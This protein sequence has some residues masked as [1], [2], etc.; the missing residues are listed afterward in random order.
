MNFAQNDYVAECIVD[1]AKCWEGR[2]RRCASL[3]EHRRACG[4]TTVAALLLCLFVLSLSLLTVPISRSY[5]WLVTISF[6]NT[7][8]LAIRGRKKHSSGHRWNR[9]V[10]QRANAPVEESHRSE[11]VRVKHES[12]KNVTGFLL[13]VVSGHWWAALLASC[14]LKPLWLEWFSW[15]GWTLQ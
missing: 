6:P 12:A 10:A 1:L 2:G 14:A 4:T 5:S 13:D 9:S 8:G 7:G 15:S 3:R 11:F